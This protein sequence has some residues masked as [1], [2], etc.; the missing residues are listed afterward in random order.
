MKV[1]LQCGDTITIPD[2]CKATI[3]D[4]SVVFEK[5]EKKERE[6][7]DG[8][9]L[10]SRLDNKIVF[11]FREDE[12]KQKDNT[13]GYYVCYTADRII[14]VATKSSL[15]FC[16]FKKEVRLATENEKQF[17]FDKMKEKGLQWNAEA[18][19]VENVR[20][21]AKKDEPYYSM[22]PDLKVYKL[23]EDNYA[24]DNKRHDSL[25]YFRTQE[26]TEEAAKRVKETLRKYH[27]EIGE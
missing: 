4:G 10:T 7:K 26:Q 8:D 16:G 9:V 13:N 20:W 25:N 12:L 6:F 24:Y 14:D 17:L 1:E 19:R 23:I 11:I 3:K 18:K 21:R 5:E 22:N 27:E 15:L 2:G